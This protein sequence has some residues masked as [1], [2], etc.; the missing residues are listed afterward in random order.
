MASTRS[1]ATASAGNAVDRAAQGVHQ[2][3]DRVAEKAGPAVDRL[4]GNVSSATQAM[5]SGVDTLSGLPPRWVATSRACVRDHPLA[6]VGVA[7]AAGVLLSRLLA[8]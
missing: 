6:S 4:R 1:S 7:V 5:H 8:R 2:M 3:I